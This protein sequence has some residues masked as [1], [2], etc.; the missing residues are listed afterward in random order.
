MPLTPDLLVLLQQLDQAGEIP[1]ETIPKLL[2][3]LEALR[4]QLLVH[5]L[6]P[7]QPSGTTDHS[8][9]LPDRLLTA[10][11]AA[12]LLGVTPRWLSRRASKLPFTRRLS[13]KTLRFSE[14]GLRRWLAT[15]SQGPTL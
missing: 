8:Q 6:V 9:A 5:F 11:E 1:R 7:H 4:L 3:E 10:A 13:R 2:A 14:I 12:G 15:R